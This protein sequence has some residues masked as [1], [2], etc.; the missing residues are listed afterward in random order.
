MSAKSIVLVAIGVVSMYCATIW[1]HTESE[2]LN[3]A[4]NMIGTLQSLDWECE[5]ELLER[6]ESDDP[7]YHWDYTSQDDFFG[8]FV[9][10]G[11]TRT[12]CEMAF[13]KYLSWISTNNMSAV[14]SQDRMFARGALA[15][16]RDMK[17]TKALD[18]IRTYALNTT[19]IDRVTVIGRAVQFGGVD[20]ASAS[21]V[22]AIVT[23]KAQFSYHDI[24]WAIP[25]Y[26][27]KLRSVNTNDAEAVAIRARGA[28][29]FYANRLEWPDAS[30]LDLRRFRDMIS[31]PTAL[32]MRTMFYRGLR[33]TTGGP[34]E[35]TLSQLQTS[36]FRQGDRLLNSSWTN[37]LRP[38]G[39]DATSLRR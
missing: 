30:A 9:T 16:C 6:Q 11:W 26:C 23:N 8:F 36:F 5:E 12:E 37:P 38:N 29:L 22:E 27:D 21:F 20:E 24:S 7:L 17:Y 19:A 3:M 34:C 4:R 32:T 25:A 31:V 28:R 13:D 2:Y 18:T 10:N 1:A 15:Q 35:T 33:T 39:I 14:D